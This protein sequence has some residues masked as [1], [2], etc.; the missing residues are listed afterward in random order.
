MW[1]AEH[2]HTNA[3][4]HV[5]ARFVNKCRIQPSMPEYLWQMTSPFLATR[6]TDQTNV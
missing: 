2:M 3:V 6:A 4:S 1:R 5:H